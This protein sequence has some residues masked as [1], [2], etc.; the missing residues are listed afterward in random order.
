MRRI[1][2]RSGLKRCSSVALLVVALWGCASMIAVFDQHAYE[3]AATLKAH[4]MVLISH[5][6]EPYEERAEEIEFFMREVDAAYEY[7]AGIPKNEDSAAQWNLLRGNGLLRGFFELW[8]SQGTLAPG[9][10]EATQ[11]N[12]SD[13]FDQIIRLEAAKIR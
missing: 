8:K 10:I 6:N 3:N 13:A 4:A 9:D 12:V 5:A 2:D 1:T 11:E 7:V